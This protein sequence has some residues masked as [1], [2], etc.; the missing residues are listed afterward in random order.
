MGI[1]PAKPD[2]GDRI[3]ATDDLVFRKDLFNY[4]VFCLK[5]LHKD[6]DLSRCEKDQKI[7]LI[8]RMCKLS[9]MTWDQIRQTHKHGFGSEKIQQENLRAAR[10]SHITPD[11]TFYALR[12]DGLRPMVGYK[13]HF[14]FHILYLDT[15]FS[16][17]EHG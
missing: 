5:Y 16:L 11:V 2:K 7:S 14:I 12:F 1:K 6:W 8:E 15:N 13:S 10:P 17:Y 9:T 4:P 3:S